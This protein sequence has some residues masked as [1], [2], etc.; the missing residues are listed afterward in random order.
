MELS[1][2]NQ[3]LAFITV[4]IISIS[5]LSALYLPSALDE[6][7]DGIYDWSDNCPLVPNEIQADNDVHMGI[8]GGD[9][10]DNDDDNDGWEDYDEN[11]CGTDPMDPVSVPSDIDSDGLCDQV[12]DD[13]DGDGYDNNVDAFDQDPS[14]WDD[15]DGDGTGN[16]ADNDDDNDF[17]NDTDEASAGTNATNPDTD[18]D[19]HFD[20]VD[21]FP[22]NSSEWLDSN[23]DG[24][25]DNTDQPPIVVISMDPSENIRA[26]DLITF[27][28]VNSYDPDGT[29]ALTFNWTFGDGNYGTGLT[30]THF[31]STPGD[32]VVRL[33]V[34]DD[35][36]ETTTISSI[37]VVDSSAREPKAVISSDKDD[38][39]D[40]EEP[41]NGDFVI[42][43]VCEDDKDINDRQVQ[44][45]TSVILDGSGSWAGCDP[46]NSNCY[47]EE[48]LVEYNWDLDTDTDSDGDGDPQNDIDATGETYNWEDLPAGAWEI[49]LSVKDNQGL[50]DHHYSTIYVNYRGV[51]NDFELDRSYQDP[52]VIT[53]DYPVTYDYEAKDRIR[54]L[55]VKLIYPAEVIDNR[56]DLY[57]YNSTNDEI[58]NTSSIEDDSRN[59]GDCASD[60]RCVWMVIGGSTVRGYLPGDWTVDIVNEEA[61][62]TE[63]KSM[64][65]ELQYR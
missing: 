11:S 24:I 65:I 22:L 26:G 56:L 19:S 33:T 10:C 9:S 49:R 45:S 2:Q 36:H 54:Y 46:E 29:A 38:D 44:V 1:R 3:I 4:S 15:T 53:W 27:S 28:G 7:G 59:A 13:K 62:T 57:M 5:A 17:L 20:G 51:W 60:D 18:G 58:A 25:G 21:D 35:T 55:R 12:D 41:P 34:G 31:Y 39:C 48:Y 32:Y 16:N 63:V 6:D 30:T 64:I 43:W 40:G 50:V 23:G 8:D 42:V 14:E 37:T 47:A 61:Y 52:V